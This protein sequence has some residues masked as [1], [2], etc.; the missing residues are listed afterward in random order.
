MIASSRAALS[1]TV[2]E[3]TPWVTIPNITSPVCGPYGPIPRLVL[4][5]TRPLQAAGIRTEPPPSLAPAAGTMP[6]ATAAPDPP[7][8][9][10]GVR[11]MSQ[12]LRAAPHSSGS[13]T[14]FAPN[15]GVF[16][17]PKMTSP[18]SRKRCVTRAW[19]SATSSAR[20]REPLD[21][22]KPA[23]SCPRSFTRNG[24]PAKEP[25]RPGSTAWASATSVKEA[26]TA[27]IVG[28]T[29]SQRCRAFEQ[30]D[31][32]DV[33]LGHQAGQ[34]RRVRAEVLAQVHGRSLGRH[35]PLRLAC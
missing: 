23:Y 13:V 11:A 24:T 5:P 18:A 9:P 8:E 35:I 2:R 14:P 27:L 33:L 17:L 4:R 30:L 20:A 7:D 22:G 25:D 26:T 12:G 34:S 6:A 19:P 3:T 15:S 10:P 29:A 31:G 21:V 16:V 1:R 32:G 28:L